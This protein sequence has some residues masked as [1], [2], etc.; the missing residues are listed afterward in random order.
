MEAL[1]H[2]LV[3]GWRALRRA[4]TFSS[5]VIITLALGIGI[6]TAMFSAFDAFVM[7]PLPFPDPGRL[8][9][10]WE[11]MPQMGGMFTDRT[12]TSLQDFREWRSQ[13]QSFQKMGF[14][15]KG[16]YNLTG[17]GIPQRLEAAAISANF[18]DV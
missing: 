9:M 17:V 18:F 1:S 3:S 13:A 4:H 14:I 6:N 8:A 16:I 15:A 12:P 10:V 11:S 7:R 2:D 5:V